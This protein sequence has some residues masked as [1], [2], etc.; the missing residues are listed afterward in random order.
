[1]LSYFFSKKSFPG[2]VHPSEEKELTRNKPITVLPWTGLVVVPFS[3][4]TGQPAQ[5]L[6]KPGDFVKTGD[7]IGQAQ[8][9]ISANIHAPVTGTVIK[10]EPRLTITGE[11]ILSAVIE[12][13]TPEELSEKIQPF[14]PIEKLSPTEIIE[15]IKGAG[16]VGLGGA[17]FPTHVKLTP[18][19]GKKIT[20]LLVNGAE[21]EPYLNVDFRLMVETPEK[22][23]DGARAIQKAVGADEV[24]IG[25][26][27]NKPEAILKIK[28]LVKNLTG[29]RV[30]VLKTKYPQG[31]EKQLIKAIFN[32][33]VPSGGLP[34]DLGIVVFNVSTLW[35][36]EQVLKTGRPLI[37]RVITVS[38]AAIKNPGNYLVRIGT[39]VKDI[40]ELT[41]GFKEEPAKII[42]GGPMMGPALFSLEVPLV[43][44][45]SGLI[46][47][48][49]KSVISSEEGPCLRCG[50]CVD[51]CPARLLPSCIS[52]AVEARQFEKARELYVLDCMECGA[53]GY[54]CPANRYLVQAIK[55]A[56][57]E[58]LSKK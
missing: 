48:T 44:G 8:G 7:L 11:E 28:A 56:K 1:M 49:Q 50:K 13:K 43:K 15:I 5:P 2:G 38:G 27:D 46:F 36:I 51:T 57:R 32:K 30:T 34:L 42:A 22:I 47:L 21:C 9:F 33:E 25:I 10:V 37:E 58:V 4:H 31:G 54:I 14:Q 18:P 45:T 24:V 16:I 17:A 20:T 39:P 52:E 19:P 40:V 3:Q 26:E 53:C 29:W 41:G 55:I 35:A 6:V 12:T 23:I